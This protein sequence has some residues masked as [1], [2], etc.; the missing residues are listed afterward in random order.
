MWGPRLLLLGYTG[1]HPP[2]HLSSECLI[3]PSLIA[4]NWAKHYKER[5]C[6]VPVCVLC[7]HECAQSHASQKALEQHLPKGN[8]SHDIFT[9]P[10]SHAKR[11]NK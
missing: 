8:A 1:E 6:S 11:R 7:V 3:S 4:R 9:F 5:D 2:L 10:I